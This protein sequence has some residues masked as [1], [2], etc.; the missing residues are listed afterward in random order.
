MPYLYLIRCKEFL[1][2]GIANDVG[3]RIASLQT[4][5]P[6]KLELLDAYQFDNPMPVEQSLHQRFA[7]LRTNGEWFTLADADIQIAAAMA[8]I[9]EVM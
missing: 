2:I 6:Y 7:Q 3:S 8:R 5:N 4:G 1:K 9:P